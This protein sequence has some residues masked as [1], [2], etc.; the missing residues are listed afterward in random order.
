VP[1]APAVAGAVPAAAPAAAPKAGFFSDLCAHLAKCKEKFCAAPIGQLV[2]NTMGGFS[3]LSGGLIQSCC[4]PG[5]TAAQ[6]AMPSTSAEGAAAQIQKDTADAKARRAAVRYL[7]TVDCHYW[8]EAKAALIKALRA[9]RNECVRLEAALALA[10]GC[11][12]NAA[13]IEALNLTVSGSDEDGNPSENS[14]RVKAAAYFAL[15]RCLATVP[16]APPAEAVPE[17]T[18]PPPTLEKPREVVPPPEQPAPRA[19]GNAS[20]LLPAYYQRINSSRMD[21]VITRARQTL[22]RTSVSVPVPNQPRAN[23]TGVVDLFAKAWSS[24]TTA[25][26]NPSET[27]S[28]SETPKS[29]VKPENTAV[30]A[31]GHRDVTVEKTVTTSDSMPSHGLLTDGLRKLLPQRTK[32]SDSETPAMPVSAPAANERPVLVPEP[33]PMQ[34]VVPAT[35]P[36]PAATG[37]SRPAAAVPAANSNSQPAAA[38]PSNLSNS[39][40]TAPV[41]LANSKIQ[42][43][44][45]VT[46]AAP[47]Q[48]VRSTAP[49]SRPQTAGTGPNQVQD[50]VRMLKEA[51]RPDVREWAADHLVSVD[52]HTNPQAVQALV[53]TATQDSVPFVRVAC[54]QCLGK[55]GA[56]T[57]QV[58]SALRAMQRDTD[59]R[60]R[61][62]AHQ[63]LMK[64]GAGQVVSAGH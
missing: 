33:V 46:P 25:E 7:G 63:A 21:Q 62:E 15:G 1:A 52:W 19:A 34:Q 59:P 14:E 36:A 64:L 26:R 41:A 13:T 56:N 57:N 10:R 60:V 49:A 17:T 6:L 5:P 45:Y 16:Y 12:C 47:P 39:Q 43:V 32:P 27:K 53:E 2:N 31:A 54:I 55:M 42:P 8:P 38:L 35:A 20:D 51:V 58:V 40:R 37:N 11:C 24:Q 44:S 28:P 30:N 29:S 50:L 18:P 9:D 22:A 3:A 61:Y 48:P 23:E 4:P